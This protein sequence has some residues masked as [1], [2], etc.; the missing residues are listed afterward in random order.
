M[1]AERKFISDH[2]AVAGAARV[3]SPRKPVSR[4]EAEQALKKP[5][6]EFELRGFLPT[7]TKRQLEPRIHRRVSWVGW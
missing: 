1:R 7:V 6:A 2:F 5:T 3:V 4:L